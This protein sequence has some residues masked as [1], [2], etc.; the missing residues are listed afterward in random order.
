MA[1]K[2]KQHKAIFESSKGSSEKLTNVL[3]KTNVEKPKLI[4]PKN[5]FVLIFKILFAGL[6]LNVGFK[7]ESLTHSINLIV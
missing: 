4:M 5:K 2:N 3:N 1:N 6:I 7:R